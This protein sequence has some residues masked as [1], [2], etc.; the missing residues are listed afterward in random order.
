MKRILSAN[1]L[2]ISLLTLYPFL[3]AHQNRN[4]FESVRDILE[5]L[6]QGVA[7]ADSSFKIVFSNRKFERLMPLCFGTGQSA[8]L[9]KYIRSLGNRKRAVVRIEPKTDSEFFLVIKPFR[10]GKNRFYLL[11]LNKKR[12]RKI[13]LFKALQSEYKI[14]LTQFKIITYLSKGF[15]NNEIARLCNLK[16]CNVKYHLSHLYDT[17]YV[18]NRTEFLNKVKEVENGVF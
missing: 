5:H 4:T 18:S 17:F 10:S 16:T 11:T 9:S 13:D 15:N 3:A 6:E 7:L 2:R 8:E 1:P 12:L 14:S